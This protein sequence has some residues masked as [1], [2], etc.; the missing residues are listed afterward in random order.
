M[1]KKQPAKAKDP[2]TCY[3]KKIYKI[4]SYKQLFQSTALLLIFENAK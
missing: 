3:L 1:L 4:L 2:K